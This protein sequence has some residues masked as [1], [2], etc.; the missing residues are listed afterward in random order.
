MLGGKAIGFV[1]GELQME[2]KL[3][4]EL[5]MVEQKAA[6][7]TA[8]EKAFT[9]THEKSFEVGTLRMSRASTR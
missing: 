2:A 9:E 4:N 7:L 8:K 6:E 5:G 3:D 1:G